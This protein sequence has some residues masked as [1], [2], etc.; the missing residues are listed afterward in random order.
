LVAR[1]SL[2]KSVLAQL[3]NANSYTTY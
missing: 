3:D 1:D 2:V